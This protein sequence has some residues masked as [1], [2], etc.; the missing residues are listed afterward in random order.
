[1]L[2]FIIFRTFS[3]SKN[4]E[5]K[6]S[7]PDVD[8]ELKAYGLTPLDKFIA[9]D[10]QSKH[11]VKYIK[12]DTLLGQRFYVHLNAEGTV[13]YNGKCESILNSSSSIPSVEMETLLDDM[14]NA[15]E[16]V[17]VECKGQLCTINRTNG[18][19]VFSNKNTNSFPIEFPIIRLSDLRNNPETVTNIISKVYR[20]VRNNKSENMFVQVNELLSKASRYCKVIQE[21]DS[22]VKRLRGLFADSI[23]LLEE[24]IK[25]FV[26]RDNRTPDFDRHCYNIKVRLEYVDK[27]LDLMYQFN[28]MGKDINN[29]EA[30]E[31]INTE[32]NQFQNLDRYLELPK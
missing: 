32:L 16:G 24:R 12:V 29:T 18:K 30:L 17:A 2:L 23:Y 25:C 8:T 31:Q 4:R 1:M 9:I 13:C 22:N 28:H 10:P 27:F 3:K 5:E 21:F 14:N 26:Q 11:Y 15:I 19:D 20:E 6:M 7:Y